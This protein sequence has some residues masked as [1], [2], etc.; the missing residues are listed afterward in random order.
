M[1]HVGRAD[2]IERLAADLEKKGTTPDDP[3]TRL[4]KELR[5]LARQLRERGREVAMLALFGSACPTSRLSST[6]S[7]E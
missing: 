4:A 5:D 7:V 1:G 6:P 2:R 3:R